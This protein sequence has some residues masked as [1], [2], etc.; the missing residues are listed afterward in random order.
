ML[1]LLAA[2]AG[3]VG[4]ETI[5]KTLLSKFRIDE[6]KLLAIGF[7]FI[8]FIALIV[9]LVFG[10]ID[11]EF[12]SNGSNILLLGVVVIIGFAWNYL[13]LQGLKSESLHEF[14]LI[15]L[16]SPLITIV[17]A[18]VFL[19]SERNATVFL[20]GI[21]AS[22][23]LLISRIRRHHLKLSESNIKTLIAVLLIATESILLRFLIDQANPFAIYLYR[24][25]LIALLTYIIFRPKINKLPVK[26][27]PIVFLSAGIGASVALIKLFGFL[28][29]GVMETTLI[30]MLGPILMYLISFC[31]FKERRYFKR[32][33]MAAFVVLCCVIYV[34]LINN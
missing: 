5:D 2:V 7:S 14:E 24:T 10:K 29:F 3:Y 32:D 19:A 27:V 25:L 8:A 30:L 26:V 4:Q 9:S 18:Q 23:A 33:A 22:L 31:Y 21:I 17:F 20:A 15:I 11:I 13:Y 34:T 1:S 28:K 12:F 16:L 6:K